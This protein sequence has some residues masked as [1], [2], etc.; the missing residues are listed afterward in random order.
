MIA[1]TFNN[2]VKEYLLGTPESQ[3]QK[4]IFKSLDCFGETVKVQKYPEFLLM[5][6]ELNGHGTS[7][8]R[9]YCKAISS[10]SSELTR[11]VLKATRRLES[12]AKFPCNYFC[13][14]RGA[15]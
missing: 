4:R 2:F 15:H 7:N 8:G 13:T 1:K 6:A 3:D 9:I 5:V 11:T 12:V 10:S 14:W